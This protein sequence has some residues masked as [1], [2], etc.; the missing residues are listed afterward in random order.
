MMV[1]HIL[2]TRYTKFSVVFSTITATR[3]FQHSVDEQILI[4]T[5]TLMVLRHTREYARN[6]VRCV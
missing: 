1:I 5:A 3:L 6:S 4:V 2:V